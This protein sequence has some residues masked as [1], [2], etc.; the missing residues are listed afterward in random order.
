MRGHEEASGTAYVPPHAVRGVGGE[1]SGRSASS[2]R[3]WLTG[4]LTAAERDAT[5]ADVQGADRRVA[6]EAL[7]APEPD[8][9][10]GARARGR[11]RAA[12]SW[13]SAARP[14][15]RGRTPSGQQAE[16]SSA[17]STPSPTACARR[18]ARWTNVRA[19][20]AGHR[21]V[22]RR[23]Q[24]DRRASSR[25][26][27]R[28]ACATRRSSSRARSARRW[29]S[30]STA[31]GRS[32]RCSSATS[33]RCGFNQ[34][35]N[36]LAKTHYRWGAGVPVVI[37]AA[38]RRRHAAPGP[39]HSQNLEAWFTHVAGLKV[40]APATPADAKGLL[41]AAF[42][43]GNPVLFLEHKFLYRSAKGP[44]PDG[45][46]TVPIGPARVARDGR[47]ATIVTCGRRRRAGRSTPPSAG[48]RRRV[49]RGDR[50]A[51]AAAVGPRRRCS[52]R[53]GRPAARWCCTRRRSPA[54]S[55]ARSP[56][57]IGAGRLRV[58]R[59]AGHAR[60]RARHRRSRSARRSR[61][62]TRRRDGCSPRSRRSSA[63]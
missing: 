59:R 13:P 5:R 15:C 26:S 60:R 28:R 61:R 33:S 63:Y 11:L 6:D 32:S 18:C 53:S 22:R 4:V 31:S 9:T 36:N 1:G 55:A 16:Q 21:R 29:A 57:P 41:L 46:Y 23:V 37:R 30:R 12:P 47:D 14:T 8:S 19:H 25:S 27:A 49:G 17:T 20:R 62:S 34:I 51:D 2:R 35:V 54:A 3:C 58:A 40:V 42:E 45:Y 50:P 39:F 48:R 56:R 43:D 24:G 10:A 7:E 52:R 38:D 44:V